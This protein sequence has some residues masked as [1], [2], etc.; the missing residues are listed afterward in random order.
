VVSIFNKSCFV[1]DSPG[2]LLKISNRQAKKGPNN[3]FC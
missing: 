3:I 2:K 1:C